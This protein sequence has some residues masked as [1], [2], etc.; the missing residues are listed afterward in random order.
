MK[1][2]TDNLAHVDP[3]KLLTAVFRQASFPWEAKHWL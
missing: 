3:F 1:V 2:E